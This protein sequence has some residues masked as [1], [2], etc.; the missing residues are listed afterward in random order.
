MN[1][2]DQ[3]R[4]RLKWTLGA[5][6]AA[7]LCASAVLIV[8][9]FERLRLEAFHGQ[10]ALA[11]EVV[12][13]M[14][15][16]LRRLLAVE[17]GRPPTDYDFLV[18]S[19]ERYVQ[20]SPLSSLSPESA[21]PGAVGYFQVDAD[22]RFSTPL[23]PADVRDLDALELTEREFEERRRSEIRLRR[24]LEGR[25]TGRPQPAAE[26]EA[27]APPA[28][29]QAYEDAALAATA[30][31]QDIFQQLNYAE[32]AKESAAQPAAGQTAELELE[33]TLA[34]RA[35]ARG[36]AAPALP[37]EPQPAPERRREVRQ[38]QVAP[39]DEDAPLRSRISA[40]QSAVDPFSLALLDPAHLVLYR[41]VWLE[42]QRI[43]GAVVDRA[44]FLDALVGESFAGSSLARHGSL[45]VTFQGRMLRTFSRQA[46]V[47]YGS[48][49]AQRTLLLRTRLAAPGNPMGL[50]FTVADLP[51]GAGAATLTWASAVM[52]LVLGGG[53]YLLHRLGHHQIRLAEQQ[54]DFVS[55]VS[56][57][58]KTPLTAI[59][60]YGEILKAG[61]ADETKKRRYYDF[62]LAE[63]E[64]LSR[65]IGNVLE[66]ARITRS[67]GPELV[68]KEMTVSAMLDLVESRIASGVAAAG[69]A[70]A[71]AREDEAL[72]A[73]V[74]VDE[75]ALVQVMINLVDN[76][77]KFSAHAEHRIIEIGCRLDGAWVELRIRDFGP[78]VPRDQM[79][80]IFQLFYRPENELTR[81]TVGTGI[82][83][84][85]V[86]ELAG[87]MGGS[88]DVVNRQPGAEFQVRLPRS[89]GS[90]C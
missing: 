23:L 67:A 31:G 65:L 64:R 13:R 58:L 7:L 21:L 70:V 40:F 50:I 22:G 61:W 82:G 39:G 53:F 35:R 41:R 72:H 30:A 49:P 34:S 15:E 12:A 24:L 73:T 2:F 6:F 11:E 43:Q 54:Q 89:S 59:R 75:D 4:R 55:A 44:A 86:R 42:G 60:L 88:V 46:D 32:S 71:W 74:A 16:E 29:P 69:L 48:P 79:K 81:E 27:K 62:I 28:E 25:G 45:A 10:R 56:H 17:E 18:V 47:G 14:N 33:E 19:G 80:K 87:R 52:A 83:L 66:L 9:S 37:A 5:I 1:R 84:A 68:L 57:E 20:R 38:V 90:T 78:G 3:Q 51:L 77:I 8:Q 26:A 76:A 36:G 63:S 85:L